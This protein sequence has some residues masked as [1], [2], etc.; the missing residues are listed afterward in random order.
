MS[1]QPYAL[2]ESVL[3]QAR[4]AGADAADV[5]LIESASLAVN[6]RLGRIDRL[7]RAESVDLGLR[8]FVGRRHAVVATGDLSPGGLAR[9]AEQ[10]VGIARA[11]PEDAFA[12]LAEPGQI[13]RAMPDLG[14]DADDEPDV[15]ALLARAALAEDTA[16]AGDRITNSEGAEAS[17]SASTITLAATNGF[18][19]SYRRSSH[20]LAVSVVAGEGT[21]MER[22]YDYATSVRGADLT[23]P[24]AI[25]RSA[26]ERAARRLGAVKVRSQAVPVVYDPRVAN[27]LVGHV[28]SAI[29]GSAVA[30][31]TTFLRDRMG[32]AVLGSGISIVEDP[33]LAGGRRSRPFD[34]E[35]IAPAPRRLIDRGVLTSWLLDLSTARQLGLASTGHAARGV[36][37][38]PSPSASN[39]VMEAGTIAR[40]D[41]LGD[42]KEG[43]YVTEMIGM[44][45]NLLTGDYSRGASGFWIENGRLTYP[46]SEITIAGN[47]K[48]MFHHMTPADDLEIRYGIDAPTV[49]VDGLTLAGR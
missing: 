3:A 11:V 21:A 35:G 4:A 45:L 37:S 24:A 32:E 6:R 5:L 20:S 22:D 42:I 36:G 34:A 15:E 48:D 19:G 33:F 46:V 31:R 13:S 10:A 14:L 29:N 39:V 7:E 16:L 27:S 40:D 18:V 41:L 8:V 2:T 26:A 44:G 17:W 28:L 1:V 38:N 49:R 25:G 43:F 47:L 9:A 12:G 30:R 23:D